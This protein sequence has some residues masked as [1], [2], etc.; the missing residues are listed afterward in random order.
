MASVWLNLSSF[1]VC[2]FPGHDL[3]SV[4]LEEAEIE[5]G[6]G[7]WPKEAGGVSF[8]VVARSQVEYSNQFISYLNDSD[9]MCPRYHFSLIQ[10]VTH[11]NKL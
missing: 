8:N 7:P 2:L 11:K 3:P 5:L 10:C 9:E 6:F 4:T 1:I